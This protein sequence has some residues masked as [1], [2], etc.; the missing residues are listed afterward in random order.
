MRIVSIVGAG[1]QFIKATA[2][3]RRIRDK[4]LE[5]ILAHTGQHY[6]S[7]AVKNSPLATWQPNKGQRRFV[8]SLTNASMMLYP[9]SIGM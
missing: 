2:V 6:D 4:G 5:E 1:P 8:M 7:L 9:I 3:S